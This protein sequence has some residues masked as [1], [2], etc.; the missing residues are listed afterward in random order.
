MRI[1]IHSIAVVTLLLLGSLKSQA[2]FSAHKS[3]EKLFSGTWINKKTTRHLEISFE[4]GYATIIDWTSK[5]QKPESG[6]VYKAFLKNGILVMPEDKEHHAPYS[7][8]RIKGNKLIYLSRSSLL[9]T[10]PKW[11][12]E[13]FTRTAN[14]HLN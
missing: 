2:Q 8:I 11:D 9:E 7:E 6:D 14:P 4:N 10:S 5:F 1:C 3:T 12:K 13:E